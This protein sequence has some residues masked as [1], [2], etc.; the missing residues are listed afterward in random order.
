MFISLR[1][2][3]ISNQNNFEISSHH[4]QNGKDQQNNGQYMLKGSPFSLLVGL[5]TLK[6]L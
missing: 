6:P 4:S 3:G 1:N 2:L 5:Q